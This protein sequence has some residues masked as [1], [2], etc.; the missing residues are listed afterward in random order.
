MLWCVSPN[1]KTTLIIYSTAFKVKI[2]ILKVVLVYWV[3]RSPN[4]IPGLIS[5]DYTN[6][7]GVAQEGHPVLKNLPNQIY[8]ATCCGNPL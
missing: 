7:S 5:E 8:G 3:I 6:P 4:K 2:A 1:L